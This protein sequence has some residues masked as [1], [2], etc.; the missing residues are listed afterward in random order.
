M[1]VSVATLV[2]RLPAISGAAGVCEAVR[3]VVICALSCAQQE[4]VL[5]VM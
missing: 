3:E 4:P 5:L 2:G 1:S